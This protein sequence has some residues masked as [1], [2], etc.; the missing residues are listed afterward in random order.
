MKLIKRHIAKS[1]SWR[2]IGTIDGGVFKP[3]DKVKTLPSGFVSTIKTI[4]AGMI[5]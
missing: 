2:F 3:G 1:L 5:I 4:G